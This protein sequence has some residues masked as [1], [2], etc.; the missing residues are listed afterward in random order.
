MQ[1]HDA[2]QALGRRLSYAQCWE[3]WRVLVKALHPG[4]HDRVLSIASGGCNS[5][6]LALQGAQVVALDLSEP[7]LALCEL[8]LA[9]GHVPYPRFLTLLGL[10]EGDPLDVLA[11]LGPRLTPSARAFWDAHHDL[12]RQGVLGAGRF[13]RYLA[14]FRRRILPLIHRPAMI[15]ELIDAK[16][17]TEQRRFY[18]RCWHTRRWRWL[19]RI[20]FSRSVG[21]ATRRR[22]PASCSAPGR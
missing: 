15:R 18:K 1:R 12:L 10:A 22:S 3:D 6:A 8:K 9:G 19:F 2:A 20:F 5:L 13:E 21:L 16:S 11:E 4:P 7:Q 17:P 14:L